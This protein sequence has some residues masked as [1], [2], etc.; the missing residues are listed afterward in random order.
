MKLSQSEIDRYHRDGVIIARGALTDADLQPVIAELEAWID[1]RAQALYAEGKIQELHE[2]A[3]FSQRYGLLF[4]E[5]QE[6]G[7]G[8]DI[9]HYR[10]QAI[11]DFLH[12]QNL[13]DAVEG[14]TG[15]EITCNPIQHLRAKP[16]ERFDPHTGPSFHVVPWHQD[17][18]VMMPEAEGSNVITCWLPLGDATVEMGCME[19]LPGVHKDGYLRHKKEGG[20]TIDPAQM[21]GVT[22]IALECRKGDIVFMSRFTPHRSTPNKS[23]HCRWSLDLRYQTTGHHT[24]RTAHPDF[25]VRSQ[26]NPSTVMADYAEWCRLWIDAFEN[27]KGVAA[28]RAE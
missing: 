7:K 20:T 6:I 15:P 1:A 9:M 24:G 2:E 26:Q 13:L 28:H 10:G 25:V 5:C 11:F 21:P 4:G 18:G 16:P 22:P 3:P 12:N 8:M 17:A 14:L 27:P 23:E 19:V